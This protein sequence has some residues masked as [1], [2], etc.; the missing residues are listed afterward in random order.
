MKVK[1]LSKNTLQDKKNPKQFYEYNK[2]YNVDIET[3]KRL[4]ESGKFEE[5]K[6]SKKENKEVIEESTK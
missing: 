3:G 2:E 1:C 6:L 4:I 5:V